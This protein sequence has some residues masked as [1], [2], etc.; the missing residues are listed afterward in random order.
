MF[1]IIPDFTEKET[2]YDISENDL[3]I[4]RIYYL[5]IIGTGKIRKKLIGGHK[6]RICIQM[7]LLHYETELS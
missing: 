1:Y 5:V 7:T 3:S 6:F 4:K 2:H